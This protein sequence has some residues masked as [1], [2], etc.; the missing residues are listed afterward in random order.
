MFKSQKI[1]LVEV[2]GILF[3]S[4]NAFI[5]LLPVN[6]L[7]VFIEAQFR[8]SS[9]FSCTKDQSAVGFEITRVFFEDTEIS[10]LGKIEFTVHYLASSFRAGSAYE[11]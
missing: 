11:C 7:K 5:E 6:I 9:P 8:E 1:L 4:I 3:R 10:L 2:V